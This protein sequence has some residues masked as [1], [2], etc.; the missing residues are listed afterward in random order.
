MEI[1]GS[2][3]NSTRGEGRNSKY[4]SWIEVG[5]LVQQTIW[6]RRRHCSRKTLFFFF[7]PLLLFSFRT[8]RI[9]MRRWLH[10]SCLLLYNLWNRMRVTYDICVNRISDVRVLFLISNHTYQLYI[11]LIIY[12]PQPLSLLALSRRLLLN[13]SAKIRWNMLHLF[14]HFTIQY[15]VTA[16]HRNCWLAVGR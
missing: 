6:G 8:S 3:G 16:G 12:W 7:L 14:S 4:V 15:M 5:V 9:Q 13:M 11:P 1:R 10:N 2:R